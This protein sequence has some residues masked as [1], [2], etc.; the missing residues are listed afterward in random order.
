MSRVNPDLDTD[1]VV[2]DDDINIKKSR[3]IGHSVYA[4]A[5]NTDKDNISN[6]NHLVVHTDKPGK[7]LAKYTAYALGNLYNE[8]VDNTSREVD[9]KRYQS[10]LYEK[11]QSI[12][13]L[14]MEIE[15]LRN[16]A[17]N[18]N[19]LVKMEDKIKSKKIEKQMNKYKSRLEK[20]NIQISCYESK[21]KDM[22]NIINS[23]ENGSLDECSDVE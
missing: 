22:I 5:K 7:H 6:A 21:K 15:S 11:N 16:G 2:Y 10:E 18:T 9:V 3:T 4:L 19:E 12:E 20:I 17:K 8:V 13:I 1:I 14:K 23:L